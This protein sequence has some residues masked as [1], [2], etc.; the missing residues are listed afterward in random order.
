MLGPTLGRKQE[1]TQ[2]SEGSVPARQHS[3]LTGLTRVTCQND[4]TLDCWVKD[5]IK[6]KFHL[7]VSIAF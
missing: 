5:T 6:I 7:F 4:S 1:N 2:D 3:A